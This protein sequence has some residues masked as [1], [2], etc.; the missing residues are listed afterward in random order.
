MD[1]PK[2][3]SV[4]SDPFQPD[5]D[6]LVLLRVSEK[7]MGPIIQYTPFKETDCCCKPADIPQEAQK[8][9]D[10]EAKGLVEYKIDLD[11]DY[12]TAGLLPSNPLRII[13]L[14]RRR[15][16]STRFPS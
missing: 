9:L 1:L 12:W 5:G 6:R 7:G 10:K 3:R 11:Y 16:L 4:V 14:F 15:G 2:I 13:I 8:Y